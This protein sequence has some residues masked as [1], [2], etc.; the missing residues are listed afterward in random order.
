[1]K[2]IVIDT[3][4]K[5]DYNCSFAADILTDLQNSKTVQCEKCIIHSPVVPIWGYVWK[6]GPGVQ[7]PLV[8]QN[9]SV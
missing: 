3:G 7:C 1:M 8:Y 5:N 6:V 4:V 2:F 9:F